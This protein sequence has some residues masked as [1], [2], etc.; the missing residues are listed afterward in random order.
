MPRFPSFLLGGLMLLGGAGG[1]GCRATSSKAME[2]PPP[3]VLPEAA[4]SSPLDSPA[5]V[6]PVYDPSWKPLSCREE[7]PIPPGGASPLDAAMAERHLEVKLREAIALGEAEVG[8]GRGNLHVFTQLSLAWYDLAE[9]FLTEKD[10]RR[11][12]YLKG[13]EVG[14]MGLRT[15][16]AFAAALEDGK[17]IPEAAPLLTLEEVPAAFWTAANW[18]RWGELKGILSVAFDIPKVKALNTVVL[19]LDECYFQ[20]GVHRF[21]GAYYVEIPAFAGRSPE[22]SREHFGKALTTFPDDLS[23]HLLYAQYYCRRTGNRADFEKALRHILATPVNPT[24]GY[25]FEDE[26]ARKSAAIWLSEINEHFSD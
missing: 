23:N 13:K 19:K 21:F 20:G 5:P 3:A 14:L 26:Q 6:A 1:W 16:A 24:R 11:D 22:L 12:A 8:A 17:K 18:A 10:Q 7:G 2:A 9:G 25:R 15:N 4:S